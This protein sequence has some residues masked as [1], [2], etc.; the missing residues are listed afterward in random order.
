LN[1]YLQDGR[2]FLVEP[3]PNGS[4]L[5]VRGIAPGDAGLY[6]CQVSALTPVLVQHRVQVRTRPA[7]Q[8]E[9]AP[10][11]TVREAGRVTLTCAVLAGSPEPRLLWRKNGGGVMGEGRRLVLE[12]V[13]RSEAGIYTCEADNGFSAEAAVSS[14][15]LIVHCE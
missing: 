15:E 9:Q 1:K 2:R 14:V 7:I 5:V 13:Q 4:S 11:V 10:T 3:E 8:V 12:P 6:T